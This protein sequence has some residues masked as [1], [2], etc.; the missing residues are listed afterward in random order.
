MVQIE[1]DSD[2]GRLLDIDVLDKNGQKISRTA[3][4]REQRKCFLC[5]ETAAACSRSRKHSWKELMLQIIT[6]L[7]EHFT[8]QFLDRVAANAA[9]ALLYEVATT[10][11]PGLVG[12]FAKP[13]SKRKSSRFSA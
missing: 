1:E 12:I 9:K 10:P 11:K 5:G 2:F 13:F 8:A 4:G 3:V 7:Q 6:I